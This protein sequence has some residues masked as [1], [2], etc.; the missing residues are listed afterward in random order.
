MKVIIAGGTGRV[1]QAICDRLLEDGHEIVIL[2]RS[3][4]NSTD[5]RVSYSQW[6]P[7]NGEVDD[8]LFSNCDAIINLSGASI[9]QRWTKKARKAII[10][11]RVDTTTLLSQKADMEG[12]TIKVFLNASA[13]GYY[14]PG[15]E[16]RHENDKAGDHFMAQVCKRW[17][18]SVKISPDSGIRKVIIRIGVVL[19]EGGGALKAMSLPFKFGLG[20]PIGSGKQFMSVI[21][22][23]DL[24]RI[25][26][27]A[28]KEDIYSGVYNGVMDQSPTNREFSKALAKAMNKPFFLPPLPG[29]LLRLVMGE[30]AESV[31]MSFRVSN[32]KLTKN[33]F[34]MKFPSADKA[35]QK[36]YSK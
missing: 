9:A 16:W 33:G 5:Q 27:T 34:Q 1:G 31:L 20:A 24:V 6:R 36:I 13:I 25:F 21:H 35:L 17:E 30:T 12:S 2:S 8:K 18:D 28:L 10:D 15:N 3:A 19:E 4:K 14:E 7:S 32:E 23:D 11:S 22:M 29:F 26:S